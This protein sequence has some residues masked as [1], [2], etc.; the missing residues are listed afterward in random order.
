MVILHNITKYNLYFEK[1]DLYFEKYKFIQFFF[2]SYKS[3]F[4]C[5]NYTF[6]V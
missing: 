3:Y 4:V 6:E 1:Y 5:M 2:D